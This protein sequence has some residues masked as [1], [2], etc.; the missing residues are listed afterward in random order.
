M[1][2]LFTSLLWG[3]GLLVRLLLRV[4]EPPE[5]EEVRRRA[6]DATKALLRLYAPS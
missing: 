4:A 1:A 6:R 2:D 5:P 3:G